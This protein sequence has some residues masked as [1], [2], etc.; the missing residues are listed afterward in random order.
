MGIFGGI[1]DAQYSDGGVY[2]LPGVFRV[3]ITKVLY[4]KTRKGQDAFIVEMEVVE[5][6]R[7]D[8]PVGSTMS[9]MVTLDKEPALGN[10]KQFLAETAEADMSAITEEVVEAAI[11]A[12][13]PFANR[14]VRCSANEITTKA[15]RP[16]TKVKWIRDSAG[17][18]GAQAA[19]A[20]G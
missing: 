20:A 4:K 1:K 6:T 7:Q 2:I 19:H 3:K 13:Q 15:G 10:I 16:F 18:A 8:R 17:S 11:S 5:S 14:F 9:W 12:A